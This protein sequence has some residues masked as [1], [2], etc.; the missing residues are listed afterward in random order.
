MAADVEEAALADAAMT[1]VQSLSL[2][3][4]S[5]AD[6]AQIQ[7]ADVAVDA[8]EADATLAVTLAAAIWDVAVN[9]GYDCKKGCKYVGL[10]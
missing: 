1:A 8:E 3:S 7:A 2:S 9:V 6:L 4:Y 5:A 10:R